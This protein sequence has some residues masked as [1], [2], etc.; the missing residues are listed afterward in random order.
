MF[1]YYLSIGMTYEQYWNG[2]P[3][4]A[5]AYREAEK[6]RKRRKNEELWWQGMY[7]YE[8]ICD[9]APIFRTFAKAGTKPE[10]Y[11]KRPYP[12]DKEMA[13]QYEEE[14]E[15]ERMLMGKQYMEMFISRKAGE[16]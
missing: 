2:D 10:P 16:K 8:A 14:R 15:R 7:V 1:P 3:S 5:K 9:A 6:I 13:D 4:L 12:I 11:S